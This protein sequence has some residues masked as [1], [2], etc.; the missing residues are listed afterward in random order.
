MPPKVTDAL[1]T[2]SVSITRPSASLLGLH[3]RTSF[4]SIVR[5]SGFTA[6]VSKEFLESPAAALINPRHHCIATDQVSLQLPAVSFSGLD[7]EA[8]LALFT[9]GFFGGWIFAIERL[10]MKVGGWRLLPVWFTS[11]IRIPVRCLNT[12]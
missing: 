5:S 11:T 7:D 2:A 4:F 10:I 12:Y 6:S 1:E 8:V 3:Q 9:R